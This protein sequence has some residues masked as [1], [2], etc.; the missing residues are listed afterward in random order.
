MVSRTF[1]VFNCSSL[2]HAY[3][4]FIQG[5]TIIEIDYNNV[6]GVLNS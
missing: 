1:K 3:R 6:K 2:N 5:E 4:I